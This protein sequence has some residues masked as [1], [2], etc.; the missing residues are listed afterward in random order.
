MKKHL[1]YTLLM[2]ISLMGCSSPKGNTDAEEVE[3][4]LPVINLS[5]NV[6]EVSALNLSDAAENVEIVKLET[7]DKSLIRRIFSIEVTQNDIWVNTMSNIFRFSREG[8]YINNV[9]KQGQGPGEYS[10]ISKFNVD[11]NNEEIYILCPMSGISVYDF[12]GHFIRKASEQRIDMLFSDIE[13]EFVVYNNQYLLSRNLYLPYD[14][15]NQDNQEYP[16]WSIAITDSLFTKQKLFMNP[17]HKGR[18][19]EILA[20]EH[21]AHGNRTVNYWIE[22]PT[23]ID[24]ANNEITIKF[25]D[26][27]TIYYFNPTKQELES[28]YAIYT[29]EEKGD[30]EL[31]HQWIRQRKAFDYFLI[32]SY[33]A[34]ENYVY[35]VCSKGDQIYTYVYDKNNNTVHRLTRKGEIIESQN[36]PPQIIQFGSL[37]RLNRDFILTNDFTGG[38]FKVDY[39]SYGNYWVQ[40]LQPGSQDYEEF[41][42]DLRNSKDAPRKKELLDAISRTNEEDNPILLIAVLK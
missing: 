18:E 6:K 17:A 15:I 26:T 7:T 23:S 34:T 9:G 11:E 39:R 41:V 20:E 8:K 19:E 31:T 40:E 36:V 42:E 13:G 29:N 28:R 10:F 24:F 32:S 5:E 37:L 22:E 25:P 30:Y 4:G 12:E 1:F 35:L 27:D 14:I 21:L 38:D 2:L 33:Y 3:E 16:L